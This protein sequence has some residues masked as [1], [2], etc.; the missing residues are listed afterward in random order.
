[1]LCTLQPYDATGKCGLCGFSWGRRARHCCL[2]NKKAIWGPQDGCS[3]QHQMSSEPEY[4]SSPSRVQ[5]SPTPKIR[6]KIGVMPPTLIENCRFKQF[7]NE[8][9]ATRL[10]S[11]KN[12]KTFQ[13][14]NQTVV[15]MNT[16]WKLGKSK[17]WFVPF[18]PHIRFRFM[19]WIVVL[20]SRPWASA[21]A[22]AA[23]MLVATIQ[24]GTFPKLILR[25][26]F[27]KKRWTTKLFQSENF[28]NTKITWSSNK[29]EKSAKK[30]S[31]DNVGKKSKNGWC[32][33][34]PILSHLHVCKSRTNKKIDWKNF[35]SEKLNVEKIGLVPAVSG[36]CSGTRT[37]TKMKPNVGIP[38][39]NTT[40][41]QQW[42]ILRN[43]YNLP[44]NCARSF[45]DLTHMTFYWWSSF[46]IFK[47]YSNTTKKP[48]SNL[49]C[50]KLIICRGSLSLHKRTRLMVWR[51]RL[52]FSA[53]PNDLAPSRPKWLSGEEKYVEFL[54]GNHHMTHNK[55]E[56][57]IPPESTILKRN[58][59]EIGCSNKIA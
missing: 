6:L 25:V 30:Y 26:Y 9:N 17:T 7:V 28:E 44:Q 20:I 46:E 48:C 18:Y 5:S 32:K 42:E 29:N 50:L 38:S 15:K 31:L 4:G 39:K 35:T 11:E 41:L 8:K 3:K 19:V 55:I 10:R 1:M 53:S 52:I 34:K 14:I 33:K 57:V 58:I 40:S 2:E 45:G 43:K 54:F 16:P 51:V 59:D 22:S 49:V 56:H 12:R 23:P 13:W 24:H 37:E 36:Y 47:K 27:T 21:F